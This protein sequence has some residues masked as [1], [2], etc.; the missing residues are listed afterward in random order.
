MRAI[1]LDKTKRRHHMQS[2]NRT[3]SSKC[4]S[5]ILFNASSS[6]LDPFHPSRYHPERRRHKKGVPNNQI[7]H[8]KGSEK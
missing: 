5:I 7:H 8:Q 3:Q 6:I 1:Y 2:H 4:L